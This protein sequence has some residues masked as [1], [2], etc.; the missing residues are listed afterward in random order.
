MEDLKLQ[1]MQQSGF[2]NVNKMMSDKSFGNFKLL[3]SYKLKERGKHLGLV[4][5]AYTSQ[6]CN[7]CGTVDKKSRISQAEFV[8]TSCGNIDLADINASKIICSKGITASTK[9]KTLV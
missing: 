2:S 4:N 5:P 1:K 8:C 6:T 3:L 9:R 7:A